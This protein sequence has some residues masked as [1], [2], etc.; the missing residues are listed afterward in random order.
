MSGWREL[1]TMAAEA[2]RDRLVAEGRDVVLVERADPEAV[3]PN[4]RIP[5]IYDRAELERHARAR[6][7]APKLGIRADSLPPP[8]PVLDYAAWRHYPVCPKCRGRMLRVEGCPGVSDVD[9]RDQD[10]AAKM[11]KHGSAT[12]RCARP[13]LGEDS[14]GRNRDCGWSGRAKD[15]LWPCFGCGTRRPGAVDGSCAECAASSGEVSRPEGGGRGRRG[16]AGRR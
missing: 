13:A 2:E 16:R 3:S 15:L 12:V 5:A 1:R 4:Q 10:L 11:S 7:E 6:E 9:W 8:S 14:R